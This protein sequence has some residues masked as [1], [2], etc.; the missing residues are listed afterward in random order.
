MLRAIGL[1]LAAGLLLA[2]PAHAITAKEK[3]V[4][5]KFGADDQKLA[6]KARTTF[7]S[8]CMAKSDAPAAR[9]KPQPKP[10]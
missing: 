5:C 7:M 9:A 2:T 1:G 3:M 4:T 10:Q 6:G 8:R